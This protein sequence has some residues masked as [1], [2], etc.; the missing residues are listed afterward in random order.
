MEEKIHV[1]HTGLR[2]TCEVVEPAD[3]VSVVIRYAGNHKEKLTLPRSV[4][5][6]LAEV[7][8]GIV[9]PANGKSKAAV[10]GAGRLTN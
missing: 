2:P 8:A 5:P 4:V 9:K 1:I 7:L 10:G 3:E 6:A